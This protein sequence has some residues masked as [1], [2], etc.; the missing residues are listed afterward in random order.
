VAIRFDLT[1]TAGMMSA[2]HHLTSHLTSGRVTIT[3]ADHDEGT[4]RVPVRYIGLDLDDDGT[5]TLFI[6]G[7]LPALTLQGWMICCVGRPDEHPDDGT[8]SHLMAQWTGA[9]VALNL[10]DN[11]S[12]TVEEAHH[13]RTQ[14]S[15]AIQAAGGTDQCQIEPSGAAP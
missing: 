3:Y 2:I 4:V 15:D 7:S 1:T 6:R 9:S 13:L 11:A 12:L 14:L 8:D 5:P 10:P